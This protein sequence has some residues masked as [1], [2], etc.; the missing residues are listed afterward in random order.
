M[1]KKYDFCGWATWNDVEC[2]DGRIIRRDAFKHNDGNTVPLVWNHDHTDPTRVCGHALL[3]N[4]DKGVYMYGSFNNTELGNLAKEYVKHGDIT[5]L[6]IYANQLK[7]QGPNVMHGNIREVSLVLAGANPGAFI[8]NVMI[9]GEEAG[10]E[11]RIYSGVEGLDLYHAVDGVENVKGD[12]KMAEESK[13]T[14]SEEK[15]ETIAEIFESLNEK[16]KKAVYVIVAQAVEEAKAEASGKEV[17]HADVEEIDDETI[18]E[19]FETLSDKQKQAV[20]VMIG[21]AVEHSDEFEDE[22]DAEEIEDEDEESEGGNDDMK[23]NI[24]ENEVKKEENVLSHAEMEA[25]FKD[26]PRHGSL[27]QSM[28]AHGITDIGEMFPDHKA[29]NA[30]PDFITRDQDWVTEVLN[31]VHH[32]PFARIKSVHADIT[33]DEARARGY[34][35]GNLKI[36]EVFKMLKRVTNPTTLYKKQKIDRD[37]MLDIT[38]F[39]FVAWLKK[40]IRIMYNEE[41]ARAF[42]IGDGRDITK[43]PEDKIDEECIRPIWTDEDLYTVKYAINVK[44]NATAEEKAKA[45]IRGS[46]KSRKAYKGSGNPIMFMSEDQLTDCLLIED[47]NGRRIYDSIDKLAVAMRVR[48]IVPVP[49]MEGLS[50]TDKESVV[51]HLAGIYVNLNDY[52]VGTDKGGNLTMFDDFDLDYNKMIYLMEGRCSGALTKPYSAVALEYV[53]EA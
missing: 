33:A 48:K 27:K 17:K 43:T 11:A 12:N 34:A 8:E 28:L 36:E 51:H 38:E 20:Y 49:V 18:A 37:D 14:T 30:E 32:T 53:E 50:R 44:S 6:S 5:S 19:V 47:T 15:E 22:E 16:Q 1:S 3:E 4:R 31:G 40:E 2:A 24:F 26:A 23:H 52:N 35:K 13:K 46:I 29:I 45:M 10:E 39:D 41:Q 9:H 21:S 25:I 7:Q 42:L